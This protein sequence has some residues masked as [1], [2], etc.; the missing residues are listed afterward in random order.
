MLSIKLIMI[1]AHAAHAAQ[2]ITYDIFFYYQFFC[3]ESCNKLQLKINKN[4]NTISDYLDSNNKLH[5]VIINLNK[6][7]LLSI[8]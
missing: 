6:K 3:I 4:H 2:P 5:I 8:L 7:K 1:A